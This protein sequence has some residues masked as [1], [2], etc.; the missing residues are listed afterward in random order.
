[1]AAQM[2]KV[3]III[4]AI[5]QLSSENDA[6]GLSWLPTSL[7]KDSQIRIICSMIE[8]DHQVTVQ[9]VVRFGC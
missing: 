8:N 5:N 1:M 7:P 2:Y 9:K 3:V 6:L 4:D